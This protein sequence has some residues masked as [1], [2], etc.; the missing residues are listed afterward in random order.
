ML[1]IQSIRNGI[2]IDHIAPGLGIELFRMLELDRADYTVALIM[3]AQSE[4]YGRKDII[5]IENVIDLDLAALGVIDANITVNYIENE[6]IT[7]KINLQLPEHVENVLKCNNPRCIT[8]SERN[9]VHRFS[10]VDR[11]ERLYKC[12]YCDHLY[13]VEE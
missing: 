8:T 3:N 9:I 1:D 7:K 5:K 2:V 12:D 13:N 10:L 4:T 6:V 11:E